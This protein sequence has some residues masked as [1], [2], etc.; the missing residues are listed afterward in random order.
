MTSFLDP[1]LQQ[2]LVTS[3]A[4]WD[5]LALQYEAYEG[6]MAQS[7]GELVEH[8]QLQTANSV[9]EVGCGHAHC[10]ETYIPR[11]RAEASVMVTD[12]SQTMVDF[13]KRHLLPFQDRPGLHIE[14][15]DAL[16][17]H[18]VADK[19]IDRYLANLTLHLVPDADLMLRE[20]RRVLQD[21]GRVLFLRLVRRSHPPL[22][23]AGFTVWGRVSHC[24]MFSLR[25]DGDKTPSFNVG[26][27]IA[28]LK[29]RLREAGFSQHRLWTKQCILELWDAGKVVDFWAKSERR[30]VEGKD[31]EWAVEL[32]QRVQAAMDEGMPIGL[33]IVVVIAKP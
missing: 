21:D 10:A 6:I 3:R 4:V 1:E 18:S 25:P 20:A 23:V 33:E 17:L 15:L 5:E 32:R 14:Q 29:T 26:R 2:K 8:M 30:D 16:N 19:S 31:K 9:L 28:L 24:L 13:A 11:L 27:D 12:F 7:W 22:G